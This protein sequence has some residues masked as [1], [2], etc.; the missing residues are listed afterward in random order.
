MAS[1]T[2]IV[3]PK[4]YKNAHINMTLLIPLYQL[5]IDRDKK[6]KGVQGKNVF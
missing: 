4:R 6:E 3:F 2:G 5:S 1:P